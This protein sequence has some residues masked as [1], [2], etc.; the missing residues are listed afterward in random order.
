MLVDGVFSLS[1]GLSAYYDNEGGNELYS[2]N[3]FIR[4]FL[5]FNWLTLMNKS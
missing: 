3:E 5:H 1:P 4:S 2:Y